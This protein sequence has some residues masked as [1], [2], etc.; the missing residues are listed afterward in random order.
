MDMVFRGLM[1][2]G[3]RV[4][5]GM[6][7]AREELR[8]SVLEVGVFVL[9]TRGPSGEVMVAMRERGIIESIF[10]GMLMGRD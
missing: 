7:S 9:G 4:V 1:S 8:D 10:D 5:D 3:D 6:R 2:V